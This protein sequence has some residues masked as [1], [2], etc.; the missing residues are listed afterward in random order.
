MEKAANF[1]PVEWAVVGG[2]AAALGDGGFDVV[3]SRAGL[4][5][6]FLALATWLA[7]S[8]GAS[9][10]TSARFRPPRAAALTRTSRPGVRLRAC[11]RSASQR[12]R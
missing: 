3:A 9:R 2:R 1:N 6:A 11:A 5:A 12:S 8:A 10:A 4:L 7:L